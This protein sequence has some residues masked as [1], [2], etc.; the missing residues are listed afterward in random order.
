MT[1]IEPEISV[2]SRED[3][4]YLLSEAAEIEHNL[5]CCYLY[6]AFGLKTEDDGISAADAK[7]VAGWYRAIMSV[8]IEEMSHLSIVNNLLMAI[9]GAPH[10]GRPNFPVDPG[11]HP[12][13]FVVQLHRFERA[14]IDHFIFLERPEGLELPD[15]SSFVP[16]LPH[17]FHRETPTR[18]VMP[19][20]QDYQTVGH[21]YRG[22]RHGFDVLAEQIGEQALFVGDPVLQ[23]SREMANLPGL[24]PITDLK[25]ADAAIDVIV[26]QGEGAQED[27][28]DSHYRRFIAIRDEFD[29]RVAQDPTFDPSRPIALNPVMRRPTDPKGHT[30]IDCPSTAPVMDLANAIYAAM[31]RSLAQGFDEVDPKRKQSLL[32]SAAD[33]MRALTPVGKYLTTLPAHAD[34]SGTNAGMS[35][36]M[37]RAAAALPNGE[38]GVRIVAERYRELATAARK[39]NGNVFVEAAAA[40]T[41]IA[42]RLEGKKPEAAQ[43]D[44]EVAEGKD[45]TVHFNNKR[46]IHARFCVVG[47]PDVFKAN[48]DGPWLYPDEATSTE[49][50][51]AV[52][53]IC[54]SGAIQYERKDG[55]QAE[56]PPRVNLVRIRENGPLAV[57]AEIE[58]DGEP[59]GYRATLCR[60]GQS[61][62]KPF[63]DN[64]HI[65]AGFTATGE[66]VSTDSEQLEKRDGPVAIRPQKDGPYMVS[67]NVE[68]VSGTGRRV[69]T[70][71]SMVLCRCGGS[72]NKPY[73]DGSHL[74][75]GFKS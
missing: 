9:G 1:V 71:Q 53:Q 61:R 74:R 43:D 26:D 51:V 12:A 58:L 59:A 13:D 62:N 30:Y 69:A 18:G 70:G 49:D 2:K 19:S 16:T 35:F 15:G 33:S 11:Y 8:A 41:G 5:M 28:H 27:S 65:E 44:V 47:Q 34:D 55:G 45:L 7:M 52:S 63:C 40:L 29:V 31:L 68:I 14:T 17:D 56:H 10:F 39:I 75:I 67:G 6:A 22:I 54:P 66:P 24:M 36:A 23:V 73:C 46:C 50:L 42:D 4:I 32:D 72:A 48:V 3:L 21:F 20:A 37:L 64:S 57:H 60:C 38:A 25:S